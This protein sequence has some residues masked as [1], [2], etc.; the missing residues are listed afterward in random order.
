MHDNV[1][2]YYCNNY[3]LCVPYVTNILYRNLLGDHTGVG[4]FCNLLLQNG[5]HLTCQTVIKFDLAF[6]PPWYQ[7]LKSLP[8]GELRSTKFV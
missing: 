6:N 2:I 8:S 5:G 7:V 1:H 3:Y 4:E